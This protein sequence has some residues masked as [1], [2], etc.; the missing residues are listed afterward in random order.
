MKA[1]DDAKYIGV[2][3]H[4]L[5]ANGESRFQELPKGQPIP[6]RAGLRKQSNGHTE[7]L[8]LP[9]IFYNEV[10]KGFD[11]R[12]VTAALAKLGHLKTDQGRLTKQVRIAGMGQVRVYA[13]QD[14]IFSE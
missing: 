2:V 1:F 8:I 14:T 6:N 4:F 3:R 13:V 12:Q 9:E 7:Y 10:S 11:P 5:E